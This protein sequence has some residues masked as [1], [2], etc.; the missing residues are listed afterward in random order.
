[1]SILLPKIL[2]YYQNHPLAERL[3]VKRLWTLEALITGLL[4]CATPLIIHF[5]EVL[6][7]VLILMVA[8]IIA[9][10]VLQKGKSNASA[11]LHYSALAIFYS[12][13][14][15]FGVDRSYDIPLL[16]LTGVIILMDLLLTS[17]NKKLFIV[18]SVLLIAMP[19][20]SKILFLSSDLPFGTQGFP[21]ENFDEFHQTL[22]T[23]G[24]PETLKI[25]VVSHYIWNDLIAMILIYA[26]IIIAA[27]FVRTD[28]RTLLK[29]T[30]QEMQESQERYQAIRELLETAQSSMKIGD[31]LEGT[32]GETLQ[33]L[34]TALEDLRGIE[35]G[36]STLDTALAAFGGNSSAA[37]EAAERLRQSS[38][39]Q[40]ASVEET[41]AAIEQ[42]TST[43][44]NLSSLSR[45]RQDNLETLEK[46]ATEGLNTME[47]LNA[48]MKRIKE[49]ESEVME[50]IS[51]IDS[52][53]SQTNLLAMNAAIEAAHAGEAG[54]GF[55]VVADEIRKLSE[56][57]NE[58]TGRIKQDLNASDES[59]SLAA[60][61]N[62]Q[63][64]SVM[65][66]LAGDVGSISEGIGQ[67][68]LGLQEMNEGAREM[69]SVVGT[70]RDIASR[71]ANDVEDLETR[72]QENNLQ[73]SRLASMAT[74]SRQR[75]ERA[76]SAFSG[77][78]NQTET[79]R[80]LGTQTRD[81]VTE[82][83]QKLQ[84]I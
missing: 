7:P 70:I 76:L 69:D 8:N 23:M 73:V 62:A 35:D 25:D 40:S 56:T 78:E 44:Q 28:S 11:S 50:V 1:M 24:V 18:S 81:S 33:G 32:A 83:G 14:F 51:V 17:S 59:I 77:I 4:A 16:S 45:S 2:G 5:V 48:A 15:L 21:Y 13:V 64:S 68:L 3:R 72:I 43:I 74:E 61:R 71:N 46:R 10:T 53:A 57:T 36:L 38:T 27:Y 52:V 6:I 54:R 31:V 12:A 49:T 34:R 63:A 29:I 84:K 66:T 20:V 65:D 42:M 30:E 47:G 55:S 39:E 9:M 79:V 37:A 75:L 58:S 82:L 26:A 60:E 80:S 67:L 19:I 41:A 22:L